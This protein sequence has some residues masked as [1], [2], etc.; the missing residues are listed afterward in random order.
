MNRNIGDIEIYKSK[1]S[2]TY[3]FLERCCDFDGAGVVLTQIIVT[4]DTTT[5]AST[6]VDTSL[7]SLT[8]DN[9]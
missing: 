6:I 2:T 9:A 8:Y 7:I 4:A 1:K 3:I 5:L